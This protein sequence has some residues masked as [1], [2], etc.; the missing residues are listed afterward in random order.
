MIIQDLK[1]FIKA[2]V[3]LLAAAALL[4]ARLPSQAGDHKVTTWAKA[5]EVKAAEV[6]VAAFD[7]QEG[8]LYL[9]IEG[10]NYYFEPQSQDKASRISAI[11]AILAELRKAKTVV[12]TFSDEKEQVGGRYFPAYAGLT[13]GGTTYNSLGAFYLRY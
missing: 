7:L 5:S 12:L 3:L 1:S 2:P 9:T 4:G 6:V 13:K 8:V 10:R 11:S